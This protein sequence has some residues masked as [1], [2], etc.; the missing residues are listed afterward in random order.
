MGRETLSTELSYATVVENVA[1]EPTPVVKWDVPEG[2]ELAIAEGMALIADFAKKSDGSDPSRSTRL[3]FAYR[4]PNDPLD[5][6]TVINDFSVSP[7]NSLDLKAQQ[8][9]DNA[10]RRRVS[11]ERERVPSGKLVLE[12]TDELALFVNSPDVLDTAATYL[13]Y[14]IAVQNV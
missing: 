14:P 13:N 3:G 10:Q 5:A 2:T 1:D 9:G 8:S 11:F 4:E 7:F 6:W 12:D